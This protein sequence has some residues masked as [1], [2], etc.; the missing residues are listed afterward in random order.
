M[1]GPQRST[2]LLFPT[3]SVQHDLPAF[4]LCLARYSNRKSKK[5]DTRTRSPHI[6]W[7]SR[8]KNML[9]NI[10]HCIGV[11]DYNFS[12]RKIHCC[13]PGTSYFLWT[14]AELIPHYQQIRF[15][16]HLHY[17]LVVSDLGIIIVNTATWAQDRCVWPKYYICSLKQRI[18]IMHPYQLCSI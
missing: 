18:M 2:N 7:I 12:E 14:G 8:Y 4:L 5:I 6:G 3:K 10:E 11:E 1:D 17:L 9:T 16:P 13:Y 15:H